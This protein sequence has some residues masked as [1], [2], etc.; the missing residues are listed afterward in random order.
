M[1]IGGALR[2]TRDQKG[3]EFGMKRLESVIPRI[4]IIRRNREMFHQQIVHFV[5]KKRNKKM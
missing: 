1:F 2:E 5:Q 3:W 4:V